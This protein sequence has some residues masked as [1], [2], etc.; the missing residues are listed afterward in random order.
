MAHEGQRLAGHR[1]D[2]YVDADVKEGLPAYE[3][4]QPSYGQ[5]GIEFLAA[6]AHY[7]GASGK[8]RQVFV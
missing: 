2:V 7:D 1:A 6:V 5:L 4:R 8:Q 3:E